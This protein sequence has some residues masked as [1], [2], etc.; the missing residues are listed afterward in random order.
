MDIQIRFMSR[1]CLL[2]SA[3]TMCALVNAQEQLQL[4]VSEADNIFLTKNLDL[5]AGNL[6]VSAQKAAEIQ[7]RLYPNPV[8]SAEV[9]AVDPQHKKLFN[10][11]AAGQKTLNAEQLI[12]MGGKRRNEM[13][14]ARQNTQLA[15]LELEDLLRNLKRQL[16]RSMYNVYFDQ[17]T[18]NKYDAQLQML[19]TMIASY[20]VQAAK[21][22][23]SLREVVRLK[24]VYLNLNN[25]KTAILQ[26]IRAEQQTLRVLLQTTAVVTPLL[27]TDSLNHML[28]LPAA[29]SLLALAINHRPDRAI[30]GLTK[31]IAAVNLRYQKAMAVP[32]LTV[33][34]AYDQ[35][36][37]AFNNQVNMT[38][39]IPLPLWHRNQGNIRVARVQIELAD[40]KESSTISQI[41]AEV[42]AARDNM[43]RSLQEYEMS[44]H[45]YNDD[46]RE[47]FNGVT[48]NFRKR[49]ISI[50]E[51]VDFFESYNESIAALNRIR[52]QVALNATDINYVTAY[53]VY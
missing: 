26:N 4:S 10:A 2:M 19:D 7:A 16:H 42:Y 24:S 11:G 8:V 48:D 25:D 21:G 12:L 44:R 9:N 20:E 38:V 36:G 28:Y 13:E 51:F 31:D 15:S 40:I 22:N 41:G 30:A 49:N 6:N 43:Q 32:D 5:L 23:I 34:G 1:L 45:M 46:F 53:P 52:K 37:G 47:V 35:A 14:L 33:G 29:D 17:R 39:G 18:L 3:L 27:S 50:I